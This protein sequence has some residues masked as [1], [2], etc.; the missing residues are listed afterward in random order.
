FSQYRKF[1]KLSESEARAILHE[2][3]GIM[4]ESSPDLKQTQFEHVMAAMETALEEAVTAGRAKLP[5][6]VDLRYWRSRVT[7]NK[8]TSRQLREIETTWSELS[9]YLPEEKQTQEY[10]SGI[11]AQAAGRKFVQAPYT[12]FIAKSAIDA[13]KR[14]LKQ[15]QEE[16]EKQVPF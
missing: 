7:G 10:L 2:V 6:G 15:K 5:D 4:H 1:A 11:I 9:G 16:L 3:T 8:A 14:M 12:V 13:L